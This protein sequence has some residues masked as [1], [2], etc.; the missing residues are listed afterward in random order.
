VDRYLPWL[1]RLHEEKLRE[2]TGKYL[3][4]AGRDKRQSWEKWDEL[5]LNEKARN[6]L[7]RGSDEERDCSK[8][9][10]GQSSTKTNGMAIK[11]YSSEAKNGTCR[12]I[13]LDRFE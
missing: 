1:L 11:E 7:T 10:L 3:L 2:P 9:S 4:F 5:V 8:E 13:S 6:L 12:A